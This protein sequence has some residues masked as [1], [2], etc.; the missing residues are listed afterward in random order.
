MS[1]LQQDSICRLIRYQM[2]RDEAKKQGKEAHMRKWTK[3]LE[4]EHKLLEIIKRVEARNTADEQERSTPQ[5]SQIHQNGTAGANP[6][7]PIQK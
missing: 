3:A 1:P 5:C 6:E 7:R 4:E 2:S